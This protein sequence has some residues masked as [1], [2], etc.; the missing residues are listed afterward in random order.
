MSFRRNQTFAV[1]LQQ[2]GKI[3]IAGSANFTGGKLHF[4][5]ARYLS[6]GTLD[7]SFSHDGKVRTNF[8]G[9]AEAL[10]LAIQPN[11]GRLVVTGYTTTSGSGFANRDF[12]LARYHAITCN[13]VAVTRIGTAGNDTIIGTSGTDVIYGFS[14][15]DFIDGRGDNDIICGGTGDDTLLGGGGDDI[16]RGGPGSDV[17][18]GGPHIVGDRVTDCEVVNGVP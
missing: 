13:G 17:C 10:A 18:R 11:D 1:A 3:V 7:A 6:D 4:A 2:D 16:L 14:G 5:L 9:A 15:N 8:A 12:A